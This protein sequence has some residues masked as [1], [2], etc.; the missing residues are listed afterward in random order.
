M[1]KKKMTQEELNLY[2]QRCDEAVS[3][4]RDIIDRYLQSYHEG[5]YTKE[6]AYATRLSLLSNKDLIIK[7]TLAIIQTPDQPSEYSEKHLRIWREQ[8][9]R[10]D[11]VVNW[12]AF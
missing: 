5:G 3:L 4:T 11:I 7:K 6:E 1:A 9:R 12:K 10:L 2:L 8:I